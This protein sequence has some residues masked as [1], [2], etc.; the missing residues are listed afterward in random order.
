MNLTTY[1]QNV[2]K[3]QMVLFA[4][5]AMFLVYM[6]TQMNN[7]TEMMKV[8]PDTLYNLCGKTPSTTD[9]AGPPQSP[10]AQRP[11]CD[12]AAFA[13]VSL[14]PEMN[15]VVRDDA[16]DFGPKSLE[17]IN[18]AQSAAEKFGVDTQGSSLRNAS[19]D[20]RPEPANKRES[21]GPW[22]NS[23]IDADLPRGT[24]GM[25]DCPGGW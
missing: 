9:A 20:L 6:Y 3:T 22:M 24:G 12:K 15:D 7:Q 16:F 13:S 8:N 2:S 21:V 11:G 25:N 5:A 18:F 14:L 4:L 17:D 10:P 23:T 19:R 1:F